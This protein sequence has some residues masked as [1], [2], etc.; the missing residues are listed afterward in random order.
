MVTA[1]GTATK[2]LRLALNLDDVDRLDLDLE[3]QFNSGLD[4]GLGRIAQDLEQDLVVL[5]GNLR[6][7]LGHDG[8]EQHGGQTA[9]GILRG[10]HASIS[11]SCS[12]AAL[13]TR[14][15]L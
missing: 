3:H 14:I 12:T 13:V 10:A 15:F 1:A 2:A 7:L 9:F 8:R 6:G 5:L 4:F 11:L